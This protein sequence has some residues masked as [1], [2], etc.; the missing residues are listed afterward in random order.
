MLNLTEYQR[1]PAQLADW[2]PWAGLVAPGV[3][4]NKDGS[5]QRSL[6][7][8]G[9]DLDSATQGELVATS[10]RLNNALRRLG[11]GW[12]LFI[13]AER[14]A[15]AGHRVTRLELPEDFK[16][17]D[18][19]HRVILHREGQA[20]FRN[21]AA[22]Y[23]AD[24]RR[25]EELAAD[26]SLS[27]R[28]LDAARARQAAGEAKTLAASAKGGVLVARR[29][30]STPDDLRRLAEDGRRQV[31]HD[32]VSE[33]GREEAACAPLASGVIHCVKRSLHAGTSMTA[34][35]PTSS[36]PPKTVPCNAATMTG[37]ESAQAW[38]N[39]N[40]PGWCRPAMQYCCEKCTRRFARPR[41]ARPCK[42]RPG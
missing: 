22:R 18:A 33:S 34:A 8:R 3:V 19:H 4:L 27:A 1:R 35:K 20:A 10:A 17:L 6:R 40:R 24:L 37:G 36:P 16:A 42:S 25:V 9:P 26:G 11:S 29:D 12:G 14:L 39:S 32:F 5:F 21:L 15:A 2:L 23:G 28:E 38:T 30:G 7:F 41:T 31:Q 13:E